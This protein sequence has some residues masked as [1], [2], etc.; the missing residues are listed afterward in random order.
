MQYDVFLSFNSKDIQEVEMINRYLSSGDDAL[1]CWHSEGNIG[2]GHDH[3][4]IVPEMIKQ[5]AIFLLVLSGN[6]W[7]SSYVQNEISFAKNTNKL[8]IPVLIDEK[9]DTSQVIYK[10][11]DAQFLTLDWTEPSFERIKD[12]LRNE[13]EKMPASPWYA[14][15]EEEIVRVKSIKDAQER[16]AELRRIKEERRQKQQLNKAKRDAE[17]KVLAKDLDK[18]RKSVSSK[19]YGDIDE[20]TEA[21][22]AAKLKRTK[23]ILLAAVVL[24]A[25]IAIAFSYMKHRY[26]TIP[27]NDYLEV[28][29]SGINGFGTAEVV[30]NEAD[31]NDK[32]S[33]RIK[34]AKEQG[35]EA[36]SLLEIS[37]NLSKSEELTNGE[38]IELSIESDRNQFKQEYGYNLKFKSKSKLTVEG[39]TEVETFDPFDNLSVQFDG[40]NGYGTVLVERFSKN[41][42]LGQGVFDYMVSENFSNG[43]S[44]KVTFTNNNGEDPTNEFAQNYGKAPYPL[45][46]TY[47]VSGL[48]EQEGFDAFQSL[49]VTYEGLD[50]FGIA[51][52]E[53][54]EELPEN[55]QFVIDKKEDLSNGDVLTVT[56]TDAWGNDP[57][58]LCQSQLG[59]NPTVLKKSYTVEGLGTY[60]TSIDQISEEVLSTIKEQAAD[61]L[62]AYI[63]NHWDEDEIAGET[64]Y[65]GAYLLKRKDGVNNGLVNSLIFVFCTN[66]E[67]YWE[68]EDTTEP[69]YYYWYLQYDDVYVDAQGNHS[70]NFVEY[71]TTNHKASHVMEKDGKTTSWTY[72]GYETMQELRTDFIDKNVERYTSETSIDEETVFA[73]DEE[74]YKVE[75]QEEETEETEEADSEED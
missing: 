31:F 47:T 72:Y 17:L 55:L 5:S 15:N 44:F 34:A 13:L 67:N 57:T 38:E 1:K 63:T 11:G 19:V 2:A 40:I 3:H 16:E 22:A 4:D 74:T 25:V 23:N 30:F 32:Y 43:D 36:S 53:L 9:F 20:T 14:A 28:S 7:A 51:Q 70:I 65:E 12:A 42:Y 56:L 48:T 52:M 49:E 58:E 8:I 27:I 6:S 71:D 54:T 50:G 69:F 61:V 64:T 37:Y 73:K 60:V 26:Y 75:E 68:K 45:E 29:Y 46:K 24:I 18:F 21:G 59:L 66:L 33:K 62:T 39:L 10:L 41:D 35:V